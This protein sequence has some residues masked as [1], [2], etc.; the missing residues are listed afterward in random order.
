MR[1]GVLAS[2]PRSRIMFIEIINQSF[3]ACAE[4]ECFPCLHIACE[5][6]T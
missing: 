4:E 2:K 6:E 1:L 3:Y 5:R